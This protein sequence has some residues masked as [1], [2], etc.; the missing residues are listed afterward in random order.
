[1]ERNDP[2]FSQYFGPG[3]EGSLLMSSKLELLSY[4]DSYPIPDSNLVDIGFQNS[5]LDPGNMDSWSCVIFF[6][7]PDISGSHA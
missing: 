2:D 7:T 1:M 6:V 4:P 3:L 5:H